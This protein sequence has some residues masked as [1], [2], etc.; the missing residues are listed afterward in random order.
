VPVASQRRAIIAMLTASGT[1]N[2]E[3]CMLRWQDLDFSHGKI[4]VQAAK[5]NRGVREIDITPWLREELL[6]YKA[7]LGEVDPDAP[8][9]P[10]RA[11]TF[12]D[13]NNLNRRVIAPVQHAA[14]K[15]REERQLSALPTRLSAHVFRRTYA[16]LMIEAGAP[17][18]YV[19]RQLGHGSAR[20]TLEVYTR[21]S[22][23]QDR[24]TLGRAFDDLMA[25]A[26]CP[27]RLA[28]RPATP[29]W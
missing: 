6:G 24:A 21:V 27:Q 23:S 20:L 29:I 8:V 17:P 10:T 16:T 1:R 7:S 3:L 11:G 2:T 28:Q 4:R 9:F 25:P 5:T 15:L 14:G 26:P 18:R 13:K 22:D 19:Q 12:R